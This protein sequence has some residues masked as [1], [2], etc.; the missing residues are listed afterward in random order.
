[1]IKYHILED[2]CLCSCHSGWFFSFSA[3]L[4]K[5]EE[6]GA[7][8]KLCRAGLPGWPAVKGSGFRNK[9]E[10]SSQ[11]PTE[12]QRC[13]ERLKW[14]PELVDLGC[15]QALSTEARSW[16][17]EGDGWG[18]KRWL[19][20]NFKPTPFLCYHLI[21]PLNSGSSQCTVSFLDTRKFCS[22]SVFVKS[23]LLSPTKL[24]QV[25]TWYIHPYSIVL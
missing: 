24:A 13:W 7:Q 16:A 10:G 6:C 8:G 2:E 18:E 1:M 4:I 21:Y 3:V 5:Q 15:L 12:A 11:S 20:P 14:L 17:R 22:R 19:N 25:P 23:N 9:S